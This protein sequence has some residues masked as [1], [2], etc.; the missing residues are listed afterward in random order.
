MMPGSQPSDAPSARTCRLV[1][2]FGD[3]YVSL[4][5]TAL[6]VGARRRYAI[7]FVVNVSAAM[8]TSVAVDKLGGGTLQRWH[9]VGLVLT[10]GGRGV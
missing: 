8:V 6:L 3:A 9:A 7:F 10:I 4:K 5:I 2:V 1:R